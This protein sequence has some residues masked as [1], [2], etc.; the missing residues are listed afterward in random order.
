MVCEGE[1]MADGGCYENSHIIEGY[2]TQRECMEKGLIIPNIS[3]F[4]CGKNCR[5]DDTWGRVC[6]TICNKN[7]CN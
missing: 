7:G 1:L 6:K 3:G 4:E 5:I 2:K